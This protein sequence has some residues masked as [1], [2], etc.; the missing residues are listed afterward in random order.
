M[1]TPLPRYY[2]L[3]STTLATIVVTYK[4]RRATILLYWWRKEGEQPPSLCLSRSVSSILIFLPY[5]KVKWHRHLLINW[6]CIH[7]TILIHLTPVE[8][9]VSVEM[10]GPAN[11]FLQRH[12]LDSVCKRETQSKNFCV[13]YQTKAAEFFQVT[14]TSKEASLVVRTHFTSWHQRAE[15]VRSECILSPPL[16]PWSLSPFEASLRL[17][18]LASMLEVLVATSSTRSFRIRN[19]DCHSSLVVCPRDI[20]FIIS[21]VTQEGRF[22]SQFT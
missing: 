15:L 9:L 3:S 19:L 5:L 20:S 14:V 11:S 2:E 17:Q 16:L 12:H 18:D 10:V 4:L 1:L 21:L 8:F 22:H 7:A 13:G 6:L